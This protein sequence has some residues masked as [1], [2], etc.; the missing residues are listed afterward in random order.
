MDAVGDEEMVDTPV[1]VTPPPVP[2]GPPSPRFRPLRTRYILAV[3][4]PVA[5]LVAALFWLFAVNETVNAKFDAFTRADIPGQTTVWVNPGTWYVYATTGSTINSIQVTDPSGQS[6]PVTASSAGAITGAR[7]GR[8]SHAVGQFTVEVG[9]VGD[10]RVAV[11]G[12]DTLG[13]GSFAVGD[14]DINGFQ[15]PQF[16]AVAALLVVNVGA[17]IAIIVVP[18]VRARRRPSR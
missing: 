9:Q 8:D 1:V 15:A 4:L 11:A 5:A 3:L 2:T 13:G 12:T 6:L 17:A 18:I 16:W 7:G 14:F 10:A